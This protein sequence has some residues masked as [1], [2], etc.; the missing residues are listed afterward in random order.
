MAGVSSPLLLRLT[1][2][3]E[4]RKFFPSCRSL[5]TSRGEVSSS[6]RPS[7]ASSFYWDKCCASS[8]IHESLIA[9]TDN[10]SYFRSA[11]AVFLVQQQRT[12]GFIIS[13]RSRRS[14]D[15]SNS[16]AFIPQQAN[17]TPARIYWS[18]LAYQPFANHHDP[19]FL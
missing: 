4:K 14:R 11:F 18:W 9:N 6:R 15:S 19:F 1:A 13:P 17:T 8:L 16:S 12:F 10:H 7:N 5:P 2:K 3:R